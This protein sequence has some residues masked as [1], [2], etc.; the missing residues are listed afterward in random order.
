MAREERARLKAAAGPPVRK[1]EVKKARGGPKAPPA[2]G[3]AAARQP[4]PGPL[5]S[6]A[7][8]P[9]TPQRARLGRC[10]RAPFGHRLGAPPDPR[11][12]D[13]SS[14]QTDILVDHHGSADCHTRPIIGLLRVAGLPVAL[15]GLCADAGV[16][17]AWHLLATT[18]SCATSTP[19]R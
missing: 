19:R 4:D 1:G 2:R 13:P 14:H 16:A 6:S 3:R 17:W 10:P 8:R 5:G 12:P 9:P 15:N 18:L 11:A 7:D